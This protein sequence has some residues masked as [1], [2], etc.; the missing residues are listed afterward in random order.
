MSDKLVNIK[1]LNDLAKK[2]DKRNNDNIAL[3]S[4]KINE[5]I[6][7][8]DNTFS[9]DYNDL[10]NRP[11]YDT[12]VFE[13]ITS[14]VIFNGD[15]TDKTIVEIVP[16]VNTA[17]AVGNVMY[18]SVKISDTVPPVINGELSNFEVTMFDTF[19]GEKTLQDQDPY[20]NKNDSYIS[21]ND[22][23]FFVYSESI[24]TTYRGELTLTPGIW[25]CGMQDDDG[26]ESY[27]KNYNMTFLLEGELKKLPSQFVDYMPGKKLEGET[28]VVSIAQTGSDGYLEQV[29]NV[30]QIAE[31]GSEIFNDYNN[32]KAIGKFSHSEGTETMAVDTGAHA[33]GAGTKALG[34]ASH[35][36][37][38]QT[39]AL[40]NGSHSEGIR[41][42][43]IGGA[44]HSEGYETEANGERGHV[45]GANT[46]TAR[47]TYYGHAEGYYTEA[48][49][50]FASHAE[51]YYTKAS[52]S[53]QHVQGKFNIEDTEEKYA[54]IVGNG[55]NNSNRKNAHT[56]D[57]NGNAWFAGDVQANNVPYI[58]STQTVTITLAEL[59]AAYGRD[60]SENAYIPL[61]NFVMPESDNLVATLTVNNFPMTTSLNWAGI[62]FEIKNSSTFI[63]MSLH[64]DDG[65]T[66]F[67][68]YGN[69]DY[70]TT[71]I[72]VT[73]MELNTFM[74]S[75]MIQPNFVANGSISLNR[76]GE[77]GSGSVAIGRDV[78]SSGIGSFATGYGTAAR[79]AGAFVAGVDTEANAYA[80]SAIGINTIAS[81][82]YQHVQGKFNI[83][84]TEN[85]Y[86]HIVGNGN[87]YYSSTEHIVTP[88]NA[89]TLD[90]SGNAW[91][92]GNV[93][94]D[95][96]PTNDK[97]LV[98]KKYVDNTYLPL[99]GG[100]VTGNV[101]I[102]GN[103][104]NNNNATFNKQ[105][106]F[107]DIAT[108]GAGANLAGNEV[109]INADALVNNAVSTH[110]QAATFNNTVVFN[111]QA[112]FSKDLNVAGNVNV[113]AET[114]DAWFNG[115]VSVGAD[116]KQL[117]TEEFVNT[118]LDGLRLMQ[119]T[120]EAYDALETK[121]PS[122]L[123][124]I[125]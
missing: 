3:I 95:G 90:W 86:A 5:I 20:I 101:Q 73:L 72:V 94:V 11:C 4:E 53:F 99:T 16:E 93:S 14:P 54:H 85:K 108:L 30:E 121:D 40:G 51:G 48:N 12:R 59:Q 15:L 78:E 65:G 125:I 35:A 21:F 44:S 45:E 69:I 114:G 23:I 118:M 75:R 107:N 119:I 62:L 120:R 102:D 105:V 110:N 61:S 58:K 89:H 42:I 104:V 47:G 34:Y 68:F 7:N 8:L 63:Q 55:T 25:L 97:D 41:S 49:G 124:I 6:E 66:I 112:T 74:D 13:T 52:S 26:Y 91:F 109:Q 10:E 116:N 79:S 28:F 80:S 33:E 76:F 18:Y 37:G 87:E 88:S 57:W 50:Q 115:N 123:Y 9:G 64:P 122:T 98:T 22:C 17:A 70:I 39:R 117:A 46:K 71:D 29:D 81:S 83:E 60:S 113:T 32:N 56:L 84:D 92:Q 24:I 77:I 106:T 36:E 31:E 82:E 111:E 43:A 1:N 38:N 103:L 96:T 19:D 67:I 2:L 100:L 27:I